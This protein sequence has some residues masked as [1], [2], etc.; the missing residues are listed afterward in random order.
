V[1]KLHPA[2][3]GLWFLVRGVV[4]LRRRTIGPAT[5]SIG[6]PPSWRVA[7]VA[8]IAVLAMIGASLL[9]GGAGPWFD[10]V[11]VLRAGTSV[12]LLDARN[13]GP[14]VQ[15]VMLLGL[16]PAAVGPI[17][18]VVVA[19]AL[20]ATVVA[21][22]RVEDPL[23]SFTWAATASFVVLPVTW[24]HHFAALIP[25]G[26]AAIVRAR[27]A[28][29]SAQR[30]VLLL[31]AASFGLGAIGFGM[32]PTWLLVPLVVAAARRSLPR[33]APTVGA[34]PGATAGAESDG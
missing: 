4:D 8:V 12:D 32:P 22:F 7:G 30:N 17:Q 21:A 13:L 5:A 18:I 29:E 14:A 1:T 27:E 2:V 28:G 19:I 24:F 31:T 11:T 20:L 23:E 6:L 33:S 26:I 9:V 10:Y 3:L 15:V 16:G 25:C 34:Q